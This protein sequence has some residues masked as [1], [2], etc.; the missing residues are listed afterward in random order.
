[1]QKQV[2][3]CSNR[4]WTWTR[5]SIMNLPSLWIF[6][7]L[8][9][10]PRNQWQ[11]TN[12]KSEGLCPLRIIER[13]GVRSLTRST[14]RL[15]IDSTYFSSLLLNVYQPFS[16]SRCS[17][18]VIKFPTLKDIWASKALHKNRTHIPSELKTDFVRSCLT[19]FRLMILWSLLFR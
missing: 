14:Q 15:V 6:T 17:N 9:L 2:N 3:L 10:R 11:K 8:R 13:R 12:V 1:M 18:K 16:L 19:A 4:P 5:L 7:R